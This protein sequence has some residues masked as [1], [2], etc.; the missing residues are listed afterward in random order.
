MLSSSSRGDSECRYTASLTR[1]G[2]VMGQG[3][4]QGQKW[5]A[6]G[7]AGVPSSTVLC[8]WSLFESPRLHPPVVRVFRI[9]EARS[10]LTESRRSQTLGRDPGADQVSDHRGRAGFT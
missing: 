5:A 10:C 7:E 2:S 4:P 8:G 6:V 9:R 3:R 1:T